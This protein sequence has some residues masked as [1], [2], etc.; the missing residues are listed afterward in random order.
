[1]FLIDDDAG[2]LYAEAAALEGTHRIVRY[3]IDHQTGALTKQA[4]TL[5]DLWWAYTLLARCAGT[6]RMYVPQE[7]GNIGYADISGTG[8]SIPSSFTHPDLAHVNAAALSP[9]CKTLYAVTQDDPNG[10]IVVM[11]RDDAGDLTWLQTIPMGPGS[12]LF[13]ITAPWYVRVSADGKNVY[14]TSISSGQG[15]VVFARDTTGAGFP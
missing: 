11:A 12:P 4:E 9:D 6:T 13:A 14:V 10:S 15:L 7:A 8:L 2:S 1:V 3:A 5:A